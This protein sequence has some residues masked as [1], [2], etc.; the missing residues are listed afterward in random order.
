MVITLYKKKHVTLQAVFNKESIFFFRLQVP[1]ISYNYRNPLTCV[2]LALD[3]LAKLKP[4]AKRFASNQHNVMDPNPLRAAMIVFL[5][6]ES[7]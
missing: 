5:M 1:N 3:D 2:R 7:E 4:T 6:M